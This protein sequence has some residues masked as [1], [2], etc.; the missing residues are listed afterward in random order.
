[1]P[2]PVN[3]NAPS[4]SQD[5][6]ESPY[7]CSLN[8]CEDLS[9]PYKNRVIEVNSEAELIRELKGLY[10]GDSAVIMMSA[11][12]CEYCKKYRPI[13]EKMAKDAGGERLFLTT[14]NEELA[15][16]FNV[17][18]Y[19]TLLEIKF[20]QRYGTFILL[21]AIEGPQIRDH[22]VLFDIFAGSHAA[23]DSYISIPA[24][25]YNSSTE[26]PQPSAPVPEANIEGDVV[27]YRELVFK[28]K[29]QARIKS[30][31]Q[32]LEA[33]RKL[34][35]AKMLE[36][37]KNWSETFKSCM[38]SSCETA[39]YGLYRG[40]DMFWTKKN[41]ER[42]ESSPIFRDDFNS[43]NPYIRT[44]AVAGY[45]LMADLLSS[46]EAHEAANSLRLM[47]ADG[48]D[49]V[50]LSAVLTYTQLIQYQKITKTSEL[51]DASS[52]LRRILLDPKPGVRAS[53]VLLYVSVFE[54]LPKKEASEELKSLCRMNLNG[55]EPKSLG[56]LRY[57]VSSVIGKYKLNLSCQM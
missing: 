21:S 35:K 26:P 19:P 34:D 30:V 40:A 57:A 44:A 20:D 25:G 50:R 45:A 54:K 38:D 15:G 48:N 37:I 41:I 31:P 42:S 6:A 53:A 36:E 29:G 22:K 43:P 49:E 16:K 23:L 8:S 46:S 17:R 55:I 27:K 47:F 4:Q 5:V 2:I 3:L 11:W 9:R 7:L 39:I 51:A 28:S 18:G 13:L 56:K 33:M 14:E 52:A 24:A 1:M 32:Y 10:I 12:W